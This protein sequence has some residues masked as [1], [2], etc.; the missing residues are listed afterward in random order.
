MA[1]DVHAALR[2]AGLSGVSAGQ[3][4]QHWELDKGY[5]HN[6]NTLP[7][8][9][10]TLRQHGKMGTPLSGD[11]LAFG[12]VLYDLVGRCFEEAARAHRGPARRQ[13]RMNGRMQ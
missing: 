7:Q 8:E 9:L 1:D 2:P 10:D 3:M 11:G 13:P 5:V 12:K 6:V 4:A